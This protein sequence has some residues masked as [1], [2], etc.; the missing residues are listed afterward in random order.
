MWLSHALEEHHI[1]YDSSIVYEGNP[2]MEEGK[3]GT[4]MILS[5]ANRPSAILAAADVLAF[6]AIL[7]AHDIG[8][9]IPEDISIVGMDGIPS[10]E[11]SIPPLTTAR[12]PAFEMGYEAV[13]VI[14]QN[15]FSKY[16]KVVHKSL[17]TE[18]IIRE[19][20]QKYN[21]SFRV[22]CVYLTIMEESGRR[23]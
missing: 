4:K 5:K 16:P 1:V 6:G 13:E 3:I 2:S 14:A 8:L 7:A 12:V 17:S 23:S 15:K 22:E 21:N 9:K 11:Y 18:I 10:T 19:S 20:T